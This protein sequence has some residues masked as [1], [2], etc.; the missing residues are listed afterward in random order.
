MTIQRSNV[1]LYSNVNLRI[2]SQEAAN[3]ESFKRSVRTRE[4][5][6]ALN[7]WIKTAVGIDWAVARVALTEAQ[8]D[9]LENHFACPICKRWDRWPV[10]SETGWTLSRTRFGCLC[11]HAR[12][13]ERI[14]VPRF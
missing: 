4:A 3:D 6:L 8:L 13:A 5:I 9:V 2:P 1:R 12:D 7:P 11:S 14:D 10:S